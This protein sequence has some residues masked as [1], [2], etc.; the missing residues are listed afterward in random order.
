MAPPQSSRRRMPR[1]EEGFFY[2]V[3]ESQL[4]PRDV[5]EEETPL[6]FVSVKLEIPSSAGSLDIGMP[7]Q[8]C[9]VLQPMYTAVLLLFCT[10]VTQSS[11]TWKTSM[12][13]RYS[14]SFRESKARLVYTF[15]MRKLTVLLQTFMLSFLKLTARM[16]T[17]SSI[18]IQLWQGRVSS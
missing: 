3:R 13:A 7:L 14:V 6:R 11:T 4:L 18:R 15:R 9:S 17:A 10:T 16:W 12:M 2:G 1:Q 5:Q 8:V